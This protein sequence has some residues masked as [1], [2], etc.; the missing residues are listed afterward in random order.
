MLNNAPKSQNWKQQSLD[1]HVDHPDVRWHL[2]SRSLVSRGEARTNRLYF[3]QRTKPEEMNHTLHGLKKLDL[4]TENSGSSSL[5][6]LFKNVLTSYIVFIIL[7]KLN[8][9]KRKENVH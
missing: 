4:L 3:V 2:R 6:S 9:D 5:L 7:E 8:T 1:P